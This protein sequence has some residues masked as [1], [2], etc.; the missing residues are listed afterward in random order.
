MVRKCEMGCSTS[1]D[2]FQYTEN[3]IAY[4]RKIRKGFQ[5]K[6]WEYR[7][8]G[9]FSGREV[10]RKAQACPISTGFADHIRYNKNRHP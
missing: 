4:P 3:I 7:G 8:A 9:V 5:E 1:V 10:Q 2:S 6:I